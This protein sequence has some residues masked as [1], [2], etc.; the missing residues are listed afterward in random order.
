[1]THTHSLNLMLGIL[2]QKAKTQT[3]RML[4]YYSWNAN[5]NDFLSIKNF[6]CFSFPFL[7]FHGH[8]LSIV[9]GTGDTEPP[10]NSCWQETHRL[11]GRQEVKQ[12]SV[13]RVM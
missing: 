11:K 2:Q 5:V 12:G 10:A 8:L 13:V 3:M 7:L 6:P 1:M 4:E 9:L